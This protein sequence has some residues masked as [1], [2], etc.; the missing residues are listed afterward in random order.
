MCPML[1]LDRLL[2]AG[3]FPKSYEAPT[4]F[5][6]GPED[7]LE[8]TVWGNKDLTR[9]TASAARWTDFHADHWRCASGRSHS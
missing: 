5:L 6:L 2:R 8:I 9:V 3:A 4:G 7:E 1:S